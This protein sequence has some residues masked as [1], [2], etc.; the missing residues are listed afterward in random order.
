MKEE[1]KK[2][3]KATRNA[4]EHIQVEFANFLNSYR[5]KLHARTHTHSLPTP[6]HTNLSFW[7]V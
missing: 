7:Q 3:K 5:D 2:K 6:P 1:K 4:H